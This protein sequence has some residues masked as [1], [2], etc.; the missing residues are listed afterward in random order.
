MFRG[1]SITDVPFGIIGLGRFGLALAE[2]LARMGK[3]IVVLDSH[4]DKIKMVQ[5]KVSYGFV[6]KRLDKATLSEA[7]IQNC[8]TVIICIGEEVEASILAT[9]NVIELG[10]PQVIAKA[11]SYDHGKVL[12]KI[13]AKVVYPERDMAVR[14]ANML[15]CS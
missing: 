8:Q 15:T 2:T 12:S 11:I 1:S 4:E 7:G 9:L 13:G 6:A 3:E 10:V 5:D 14:L